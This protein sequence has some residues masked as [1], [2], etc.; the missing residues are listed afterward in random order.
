MERLCGLSHEL[1]QRIF[2]YPRS[3]SNEWNY[4]PHEVKKCL[5]KTFSILEADRMNGTAREMGLLPRQEQRFNPFRPAL[6][7]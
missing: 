1:R 2:Q 4:G 3:G 7:F 6:A 5:R